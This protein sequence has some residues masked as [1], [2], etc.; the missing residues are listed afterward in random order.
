MNTEYDHHIHRSR[1][2]AKLV[3]LLNDEISIRK[4]MNTLFDSISSHPQVLHYGK[5]IYNPTGIYIKYKDA[6]SHVLI[7]D[8]IK[9]LDP[10]F[11]LEKTKQFGNICFYTIKKKTG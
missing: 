3:R 8:W 2:D 6:T 7:E 11:F 10:S 4:F 9:Q 1:Y 5:E